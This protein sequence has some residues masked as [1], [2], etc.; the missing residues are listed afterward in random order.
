MRKNKI[1]FQEIAGPGIN[2]CRVQPLVIA[3]LAAR[4]PLSFPMG[5]IVSPVSTKPA[6]CA[7]RSNWL[8]VGHP[9]GIYPG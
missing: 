3:A 5:S 8:R 2:L 9:Q 7:S 6:S 1:Q 4:P